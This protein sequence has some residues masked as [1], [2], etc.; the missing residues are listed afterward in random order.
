MYLNI[1]LLIDY[2]I[3]DFTIFIDSHQEEE[4]P[5]IVYNLFFYKYET[6]RKLMENELSSLQTSR[7]VVHFHDPSFNIAKKGI[8]NFAQK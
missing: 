5:E 3:V 6:V 8:A 7:R 1:N 4:F 2:I